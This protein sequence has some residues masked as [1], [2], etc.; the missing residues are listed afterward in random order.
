MVEVAADR[1]DYA[2]ALAIWTPLAD[3]GDAH[4]QY[5]VGLLY[6][7]GHGVPLHYVDA[8]K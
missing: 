8:V 2:T 5:D 4:A 3:R 1:G 7:A 6:E